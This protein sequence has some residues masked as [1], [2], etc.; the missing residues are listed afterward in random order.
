[1]PVYDVVIDFYFRIAFQHPLA[2]CFFIFFRI[3][4][5][6]FLHMNLPILDDLFKFYSSTGSLLQNI[7]IFLYLV[8]AFYC[9]LLD[10]K[11]RTVPLYVFVLFAFIGFLQMLLPNQHLHSVVL[12]FLNPSHYGLSEP[13]SV[14]LQLYVVGKHLIFPFLPGLFLLVLH[15]IS[16]AAIGIGDACFLLISGCFLS[17]FPVLLLLLSGILTGGLWSIIFIS[18]CILHN[19]SIHIKNLRFPFIPCMLPGLLLILYFCYEHY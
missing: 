12:L 11:S 16:R 2:L 10:W 1:M 13:N 4:N 14:F 15:K 19:H 18:Y 9:S 6:S 17:G 5:A 8:F 7:S 3:S